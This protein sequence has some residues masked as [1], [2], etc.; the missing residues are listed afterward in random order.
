MITLLYAALCTLLVLVLAGRVLAN[1]ATEPSGSSGGKCW[2]KR[3]ATCCP[4]GASVLSSVEGI[5][6][7]TTGRFDQPWRRASI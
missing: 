4:G 5:S 2:Q 6:I 3:L 1:R 7:S